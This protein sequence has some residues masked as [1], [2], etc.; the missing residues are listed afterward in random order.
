MDVF[1]RQG[2]SIRQRVLADWVAIRREEE[3]RLAASLGFRREFPL[4]DEE[5]I[6]VAID[7][8]PLD[9]AHRAGEGRRIARKAFKTF[10]PPVLRSTPGKAREQCEEDLSSAVQVAR[11]AAL[12]ISDQL[13]ET[14]HP[15][16]SRQW[17]LDKLLIEVERK[18]NDTV[19]LSESLSALITLRSVNA[20][21]VW[22]EG[23]S[24]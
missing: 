7:Q 19:N 8:D 20:W 14:S 21:L 13:R 24:S 2:Q 4:L 17:E 6:A 3:W 1:L 15:L 12:A 10:L 22:L 16:L 9:H 11:Q 18:Q 5:L 23:S